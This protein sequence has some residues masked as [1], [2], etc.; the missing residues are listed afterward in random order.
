MKK[1]LLALGILMTLLIGSQASFAAYSSAC[2][3]PTSQVYTGPY[4]NVVGS[5]PCP[6]TN[7]CPTC[8]S[9]IILPRPNCGCATVKPCLTGCAAPCACASPCVTGCAA[10]CNPCKCREKCSWWKIFQN[11]NCCEK[12]NKCCDCCD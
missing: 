4:P 10:P 9:H 1:T 12:C 6:M 2:P 7:P 8:T 3:C 11:K 5:S